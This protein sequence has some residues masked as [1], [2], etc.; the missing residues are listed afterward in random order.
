MSP[1][2]NPFRMPR[3]L[4]THP[5]DVGHRSEAAIAGELMRRGFELWQPMNVNSRAD[6]IVDLGDRLIRVQCKTGRLR[7][8]AVCFSTASVRSNRRKVFRRTYE[9]EIDFFAVYCPEIDRVYF[10]PIEEATTTGISLRVAT[11]D[12]AQVKRIRWA[13]DYELPP[14]AA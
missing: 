14:L 6:L 9:G 1:D 13:Q 7:G 4:S 12:N 5:V 10:V 8:G 11:P 2:A 3:A